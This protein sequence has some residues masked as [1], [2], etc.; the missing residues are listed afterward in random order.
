MKKTILIL[1]LLSFGLGFAQQKGKKKK[2]PKPVEFVVSFDT[3]FFYQG[4]DR[5]MGENS[6]LSYYYT[7]SEG[8][9]KPMF[10]LSILVNKPLTKHF[11]V[12]IEA[13][14]SLVGEERNR[15][16]PITFYMVPTSLN[17]TYNFWKDKKSII[18]P[19]V[20][21]QGGYIFFSDYVNS[22]GDI[23]EIKGGLNYGFKVGFSIKN[24]QSKLL[25]NM[26]LTLG[27]KNFFTNHHNEYN[28]PP[29]TNAYSDYKVRR[30]GFTLGLQYKIP[31]KKKRRK[32]H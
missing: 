1:C 12:G 3:Q 4:T 30:E 13:S 27:Y 16:E 19:F 8:Y 26:R 17:L 2:T 7:K 23:Y 5:V 31:T 32:R 11:L 15:F 21:L 29:I 6:T 25:N 10:G 28:T 18:R 20:V 14:V 24:K 9:A 22:Y